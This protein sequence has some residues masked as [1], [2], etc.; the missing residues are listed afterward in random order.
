[1]LTLKNANLVL[2][3][4]FV[5]VGVLGYFPNPLVSET[6]IFAVNPAHNLVHIASGALLLAGALVMPQYGGLLLK[7]VGAV[8]A[9]VAVLGFVMVGEDHMLLG[10]VHINEADKWLH[11]AL[12]V[13]L[14]YLGFVQFKDA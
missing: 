14:C 13:V 2:G 12:A 10:M 1:M 3:L 6:G 5:L 9:L 8:Y 11:V 4:V 7:A